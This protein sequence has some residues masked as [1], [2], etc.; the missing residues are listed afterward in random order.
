MRAA[1]RVMKI[2][3]SMTRHA[4]GIYVMPDEIFIDP[5]SVENPLGCDEITAS[6]SK[7]VLTIADRAN[8]DR[9]PY[10]INTETIMGYERHE[11]VVDIYAG[12]KIVCLIECPI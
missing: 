6:I 3:N 12:S 2:I 1:T 9:E 5:E 10:A 7:G 8:P 11:G 4:I